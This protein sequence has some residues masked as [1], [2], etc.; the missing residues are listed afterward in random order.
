MSLRW[1]TLPR[2]L[3]AFIIILTGAAFQKYMMGSINNYL[4]F[5]KP[6][7]NLLLDKS[8]YGLHPDLYADNYKYSP[9]FAWLMGPFYYMPIGL[10]V[11]FWNLINS[12][13]LAAGIWYFLEGEENAARKRWMALL[14]IF[15][16]ALVTAQNMQS[17][18]L[19]IG[20]MLLGLYHLRNERVWLAAFF[21]V[22]CGFVKFYGI[23]AALF[24]VFYPKKPQFLL[25]M[26]VWTVLFALAP[27]T[28][29]PLSSLGS[30]YVEWFKVVM[31][32]TLGRLVSVMGILEVWFGMAKTDANLRMVEAVGIVLFLLPFLRVNLWKDLLFQ[33]RMIAYFLLFIIIFNKMA[34]SP[35]Y[36]L[37]VTGVAIWWLTLESPTRF[38]WA[39]LLTVIIFTSLSPTDIFP[40][41]IRDGFFVPYR[42]KAVGCMLVWARLQWELWT[43]EAPDQIKMTSSSTSAPISRLMS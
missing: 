17:N 1:L 9:T 20:A 41:F 15:P 10:G 3:A 37:A 36:V 39:L 30:E 42:I 5:S 7:H 19:I 40:R 35:T 16:E 4:M 22:L 2:L 32:S 38:D 6:F 26:T 14:I 34:E 23:T 25:A 11:F 27:A 21:F 12:V 18:N 31:V 29:I 24:F 43:Q 28:I 13:V 8:I 33:R